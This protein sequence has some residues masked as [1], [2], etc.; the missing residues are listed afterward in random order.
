MWVKLKNRLEARRLVQGDMTFESLYSLI[1]ALLAEENIYS[2][3]IFLLFLF[4]HLL[5]VPVAI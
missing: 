5:H 2:Y 3:T 4:Q 1:L